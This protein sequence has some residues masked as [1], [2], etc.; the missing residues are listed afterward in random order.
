MW[1]LLETS[2]L[3]THKKETTGRAVLESATRKNGKEKGEQLLSA[4]TSSL[5][6]WDE[7]WEVSANLCRYKVM[8][9]ESKF[10]C[11]VVLKTSCGRNL[12]FLPQQT[13]TKN[14]QAS[15]SIFWQQSQSFAN[16]TIHATKDLHKQLPFRTKQH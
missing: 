6:E 9:W 10:Q 12:L 11:R 14:I 7:T 5:A 13:Q 8:V 3:R 2:F 15:C 16:K 1:L 4:S